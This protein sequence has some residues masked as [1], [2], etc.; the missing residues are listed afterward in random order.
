MN[1]P[2]VSFAEVDAAGMS[3]KQYVLDVCVLGLLSKQTLGELPRGTR[4]ALVAWI[5]EATGY[6]KRTVERHIKARK[7]EPTYQMFFLD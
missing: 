7:Q 6:D 5:A 2:S 4:E 1:K 3:F